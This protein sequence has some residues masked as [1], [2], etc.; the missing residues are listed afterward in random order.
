[1]EYIPTSAT[2]CRLLSP[3]IIRS[4]QHDLNKLPRVIEQVTKAGQGRHQGQASRAGYS[5]RS[6]SSAGDRFQQ[7]AWLVSL[8]Q[9]AVHFH[10]TNLCLPFLITFLEKRAIKIYRYHFKLFF[11]VQESAFLNEIFSFR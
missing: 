10:R 4:C 5:A 8:G 7:V 2:V 1:M 9:A 11:F 3:V 6:K